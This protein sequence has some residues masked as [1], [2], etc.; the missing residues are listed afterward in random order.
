MQTVC[1]TAEKKAAQ[2]PA[3]TLALGFSA[4]AL[5]GIG[6]LL[7]SCIGGASP[8]LAAA[9][10][11]ACNFLKVRVESLPAQKIVFE[12]IDLTSGTAR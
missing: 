2:D 5:I 10:P 3:T 12:W 6:A 4:G 7:M 8:A 11:G 1:A 9:N